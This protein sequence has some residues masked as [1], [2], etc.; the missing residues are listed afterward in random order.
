[1][2][3][4]SAR[5]YEFLSQNPYNRNMNPKLPLLLCLLAAGGYFW[6]TREH[7]RIDQVPNEAIGALEAKA[8][9]DWIPSQQPF[10]V[11]SD[12]VVA[13]AAE[14]MLQGPP[15]HAKARFKIELLNQQLAA[16][17]E[18]W[19][20]G[21]GSRKTRLE[22]AYQSEASRFQIL[23][24][25]NGRHFYWYRKL[26]AGAE[27]EFVDLKQIEGIDGE[28]SPFVA[29]RRAWDTVGGLSS[30]LDHVAKTFQFEPA[31]AGTL[32]GI[33]VVVIQGRWRADSLARLM[34]GQVDAAKLAGPDWWRELPPHLP[35]MIKLTLGTAEPFRWFPYR[36]ELFQYQSADEKIVA[37]PIVTLELYEVSSLAEVPETLFQIAAGNCEP[38]D[39]TAFYL[40]RVHQF[41]R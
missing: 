22:F 3:L 20:Q 5:H 19:Q 18:Y 25:C 1:L 24:V 28:A 9:S 31:Q 14:H 40:E 4:C 32:D 11:A 8:D 2:F 37:R 34:E 15:L 30:M 26:N 38:H 7:R 36:V 27:L 6:L 23:Q 21:N 13:Q 10:E 16:P 39:L 41:T 35:H 29:G 17:G 12:V 33:P